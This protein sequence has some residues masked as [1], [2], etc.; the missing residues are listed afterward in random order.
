M[1][2][3]PIV[4]YSVVCSL[5]GLIMQMLYLL[6]QPHIFLKE[7][8][9]HCT[10]GKK[11]VLTRSVFTSFLTC[12]HCPSITKMLKQITSHWLYKYVLIAPSQ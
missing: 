4:I 10:G 1:E 6:A 9:F 2:Y 5:L 7:C 8:F 11:K 12:Y 3:F